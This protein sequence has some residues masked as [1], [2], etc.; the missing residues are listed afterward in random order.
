MRDRR[1]RIS[2]GLHPG[3]SAVNLFGV[4]VAL[5]DKTGVHLEVRAVAA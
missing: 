2:Q 1:S 5:Q 4:I 3:Y